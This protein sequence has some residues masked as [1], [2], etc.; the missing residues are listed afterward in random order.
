M[1]IYIH[2][3]FYYYKYLDVLKY[4]QREVQE[5]NRLRV[6]M[7]D[8]Q[9]QSALFEKRVIH[10]LKKTMQF[11]YDHYGNIATSRET[12]RMQRMIEKM[13]TEREWQQFLNSEAKD[14]VVN[15]LNTSRDY[16]RIRYN[17]KFNPAVMTLAKGSLERRTGSVRKQYT[18]RY[19]VLTQ[20]KFN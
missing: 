11:C 19:Y 10:T 8:I 1:K 13:D 3:V 6:T 4:L 16:F 7:I 9:H 5:D 2:R 18:E 12:A 17:N 20:C 14:L 15:P